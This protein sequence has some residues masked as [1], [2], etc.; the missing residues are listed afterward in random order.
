MILM[1]LMTDISFAQEPRTLEDIHEKRKLSANTATQ[2]KENRKFEIKSIRTHTIQSWY[3]KQEYREANLFQGL[4]VTFRVN[5]KGDRILVPF[6][7]CYFYDK[8]KNLVERQEVDFYYPK[9]S[10]GSPSH[11]TYSSNPEPL[12]GDL[13]VKG[14]KDTRIIFS[15]PPP[16][17]HF[18]YAICVIGND[19]GV[20][21]K[22][23]P[24]S[25]SILDFEF[26]EKNLYDVTLLYK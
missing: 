23:Y 1:L 4:Q 3:R 20:D 6:A 22:A 2:K 18:E 8:K 26:D 9:Y 12:I 5:E 14:K 21:A 24:E 10:P 19:E 11:R 16:S 25:V 7:V 17:V 13:F 15:F